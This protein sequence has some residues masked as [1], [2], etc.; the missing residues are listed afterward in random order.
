MLSGGQRTLDARNGGGL[1]PHSLCHL[2]LGQ[3]GFVPGF[4]Q[5]V[6][7]LGLLPLETPNLSAHAGPPHQVLHQLVMRFHV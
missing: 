5:R 3:T 4:Q 1:R 7:E 6:K 2:R